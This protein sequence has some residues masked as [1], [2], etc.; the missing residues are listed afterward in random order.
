MTPTSAPSV[1]A[2]FATT[3]ERA[4][5][6]PFF[7]VLPETAHAYGIAPRTITYAEAAADIARLRAAYAA[8]GYGAGHRIGLMLENRPA[9]LLHWIAL[10]GLG[11]AVVPLSPDL[12]PAELEYLVQHSEI[13]LG[14]AAAPHVNA[15]RSVASNLPVIADDAPPPPAP[16]R[17]A[18]PHSESRN[19]VRPALHLRHH[20]T[21][22][23]LCAVQRLLPARRPLVRDRRRALRTARRRPADH[24][25]AA[26]P[27]ERHGLLHHGDDRD[28]RLHRAARPLPSAHLVGRRCAKARPP[29]CTISAS[30]RRCCC[31]PPT[32][33]SDRD[34]A[35]R[36][37]FGA[38]VDRRHHAAF[39]ATFGFP[40]LE[41][42]AMTETGAGAVVIA[43]HEPRH[44]GTN[45]FGRPQPE[46]EV[47]IMPEDGE[48][49][50]RAAGPDPRAGFFSAYLKEPETTEAA[51][52]GGWFHTGDIVRAD[53]DGVSLFRRSQEERDPPQ[54]REHQRGRS[55]KRAAPAPRG[56]RGRRR[57]RP[58]RAPRRRSACLHRSARADRRSRRSRRRHR[59][60]RAARTCPISRC[61]A[62]SCS[63]KRCR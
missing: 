5:D 58:R 49:L 16:R 21:A 56:R 61:P 63:W 17:H 15:L 30:C 14:V 59:A 12:R 27:H 51:W 45:C 22:E 41:A 40:L 9:F 32:D 13:V 4:R 18:R 37:G 46:V 7:L 3:A 8:A 20:R 47:R 54:R 26:Q 28:R 33:P 50:V 60:C 25:A 24:A 19:R 57:R 43:S 11:A 62:G 42:W 1:A 55:R 36:F 53:A 34:H 10:N 6:R 35:V 23:R 2:A 48:M 38:G 52:E 29:S 31:A 39:E 44:V